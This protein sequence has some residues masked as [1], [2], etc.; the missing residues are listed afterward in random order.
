V[1]GFFFFFFLIES[2]EIPALANDHTLGIPEEYLVTCTVK[3]AKDII[4]FTEEKNIL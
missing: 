4:R 2:L 1:A 3:E